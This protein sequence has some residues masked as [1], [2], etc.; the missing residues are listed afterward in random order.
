MN[1]IQD[2]LMV[3]RKILNVNR[4]NLIFASAICVALTNA[5]GAPVTYTEDLTDFPNPERGFWGAT[6][7]RKYFNIGSYKTTDLPQS[8]LD[9]VD[10]TFSSARN[11][12]KKLIPRFNYSNSANSDA[13]LAQMLIHIEQLRPVLVRNYDVIAVMEAGFVGA[14]GEWWGSTSVKDTESRRAVLFKLLDVLP[15]DRMV[16]MRYN[17][18][19]RA[20]YNSNA[21]I[22]AAE[23]FN[24]SNKSR[25]AAQN[26]CF[27]TN[28]HDAGTYKKKGDDGGWGLGYEA[29]KEY[30]SADNNYVSQDGETCREGPTEYATCERALADMKRM[31]WDLINNTFNDDVLD[32]WKSQK[33]FDEISRRLGYRIRLLNGSFDAEVTDGNLDGTLH[34]KNEGFGKIFNPRKLEMIL[35]N[36]SSGAE[37]ALP[38]LQD[39][40]LW[41]PGLEQTF[42]FSIPVPKTVPFGTY[43]LLLNLPDPASSLHDNPRYSIRLANKDLW[44]ASKGYNSLLHTVKIS[45]FN[46]SPTSINSRA[47]GKNKFEVRDYSGDQAKG[48]ISIDLEIARPSQV[49]ID[50]YDITGNLI[51][52][53]ANGIRGTGSYTI[54]WKGQDRYGRRASEGIYFITFRSGEKSET[55]RVFFH[56][57]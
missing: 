46:P 51:A 42:N 9:G 39:P 52:E 30:L 54:T 15:P 23:A 28:E 3:L 19:K 21:P 10:R 29:E 12:G 13:S 33:C 22:T 18:F 1:K 31:K 14:Y 7:E 37:F 38:M 26:D 16:T 41:S 34:L 27:I 5:N 4:L 17:A 11:S 57:R 56:T 24:K 53:L 2:P 35:R 45:S 6:V 48:T 47:T 50:V 44:E 43:S 36:T 25:T 8:F 32:Q 55:R 49:N 40:R 20:I